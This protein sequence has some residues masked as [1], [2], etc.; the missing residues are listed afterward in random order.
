MIVLL[1]D[2]SVGFFLFSL[3]S[4]VHRNASAI[5]FSLLLNSHNVHYVL[6]KRNCVQL[7][8]FGLVCADLLWSVF[9]LSIEVAA[10]IVHLL[11]Q[12]LLQSSKSKM[13]KCSC[14]IQTKIDSF[15]CLLTRIGTCFSFFL[16]TSKHNNIAGSLDMINFNQL[17]IFFSRNIAKLLCN[18]CGSKRP[19]YASALCALVVIRK[20]NI[21]RRFA[22]NY[23][24]MI[25][26]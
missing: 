5:V 13:P 7:P 1:F 18:P 24:Q 15:R 16:N 21:G 2:Q 10:I 19:Q 12:L 6:P 26:G 25:H 11:G 14:Q 4:N 22:L 20:T 17:Y 8:K 9:V 23:F 3:S